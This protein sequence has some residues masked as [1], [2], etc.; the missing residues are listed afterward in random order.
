MDS[1]G[2]TCED[3]VGQRILNDKSFVFTRDS[4]GVGFSNPRG[5]KHGAALQPASH[6]RMLALKP[7]E[8][9][10]RHHRG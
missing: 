10:E 9:L 2:V 1:V 7:N 3:F 6:H 5:Y 4:Y 8:A